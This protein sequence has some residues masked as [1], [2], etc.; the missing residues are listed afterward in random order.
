MNSPLVS[1]VVPVYN[2]A[3]Y[4]ERCTMS[5]TKQTY[6]NI[7]ILLID[8]GSTDESSELCDILAKKEKRILV[9]HKANGGL[10]DARNYGLRKASGDY[11]IF[12]DS[13]DTMEEDGIQYL[14]SLI[15]KNHTL[16][17]IAPHYVV[18]DTKREKYGGEFADTVLTQEDALRRMLQEKGFTVSAWSKIYARGL[19]S[20]IEFPKGKIYEDN[21]TIYK[22]IMK[23]D[24]IAYGNKAVYDYYVR[25]GSLTKSGF[26]LSKMDYVDL[27]DEMCDDILIKYPDMIIPTDNKRLDV[28]FSVLAQMLDSRLSP[29]EKKKKKEM[30]DYLKEKKR[31]IFN[32]EYNRRTRIA[33]LALCVGTIFYKKAWHIY[34]RRKG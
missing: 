25:N 18:T 8:D 14:V 11:V 32:R 27:S 26:S 3:K 13:D 7:E 31:I 6:E 29:A 28:R 17:A 21:G 34:Q 9:F 20:D 24:Y 5:L 2:V 23:C 1:V 10:S 15:E 19:F 33:M 12:V 4:L 16:M 22:V 30:V